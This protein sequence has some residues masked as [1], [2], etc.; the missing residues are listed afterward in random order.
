VDYR[1]IWKI[2]CS[3]VIMVQM[4]WNTIAIVFLTDFFKI[5]LCRLFKQS[6]ISC[7]SF[8]LFT[9]KIFWLFFLLASG[10]ERTSLWKPSGLHR[11]QAS[12][13]TIQRR[14]WRQ[15][16]ELI[17]KYIQS[18]FDIFIWEIFQYSKISIINFSVIFY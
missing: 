18:N 1:K 10:H 11:K 7:R 4:G 15:E 6:P 3:D 16:K 17:K 14:N 5:Q 13:R 8:R 12:F 2:N 9:F